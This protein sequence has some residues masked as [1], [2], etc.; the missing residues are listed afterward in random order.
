MC[1]RSPLSVVKGDRKMTEQST[2]THK[3]GVLPFWAEQ[4]VGKTTVEPAMMGRPRGFRPLKACGA[5]D[6]KRQRQRELPDSRGRCRCWT[7][8]WVYV[9]GPHGCSLKSNMLGHLF[10]ANTRAG[11]FH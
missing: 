10:L 8:T 11:Q 1:G 2:Q 4:T 6:T 3:L 7:S 5:V 9:L